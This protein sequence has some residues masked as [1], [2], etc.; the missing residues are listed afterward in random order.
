MGNHRDEIMSALTAEWTDTQIFALDDVMS[1][2]DLPA[3]EGNCV[4]LVDF[5]AAS[6]QITTIAVNTSNGYRDFGIVQLILANPVGQGGNLAREYGNRLR[7]LLRGRRIGLTVIETVS[8]F[9]AEGLTDGKWQLF[10][11]RLNFYRD[12]C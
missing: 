5:P 9:S 12:E 6:Q 4:L 8:T 1:L 11:A 3:V 10:V 7:L 2:E